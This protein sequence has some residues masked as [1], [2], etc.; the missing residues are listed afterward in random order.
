MDALGEAMMVRHPLDRKVFNSD[1][2]K[3]IHDA[4]T[5]LVRKVT[6]P[7]GDALMDPRHDLAPLSVFWR[8]YFLFGQAALCLGKRLFLSAKEA[9]VSDF[10]PHA[11]SGEGLQPD[12]NTYL[13][14]RFLQWRRF[15]ALTGEAGVPL[16]SAAA[17]DGGRLGCAFERAM[18]ENLHL[19]YA[20]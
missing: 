18:Q 6:A 17:C 3:S 19:A 9:R 20:M 4:M 15:G 12:I 13:L 7:P 5:V 16:A 1:E 2:I 14:A 11:E 8:P 10:L